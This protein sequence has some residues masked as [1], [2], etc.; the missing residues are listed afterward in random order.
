MITQVRKQ[1]EKGKMRFTIGIEKKNRSFKITGQ[2]GKNSSK[3]TQ[4]REKWKTIKI[5]K[6]QK[7]KGDIGKCRKKKNEVKTSDGRKQ[8]AKISRT[9]PK[10][11]VT[12]FFLLVL[13]NLFTADST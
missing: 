6:K 1:K 2:H 12:F 7:R 4:K 5:N 11:I 9:R 10:R 13:L 3:I 8:N